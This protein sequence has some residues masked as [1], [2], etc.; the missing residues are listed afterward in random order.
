MPCMR[1]NLLQVCIR[2]VPCRQ[3]APQ[4]MRCTLCQLLRLL[5]C[6][7]DDMHGVTSCHIY[8]GRTA[9]NA[10]LVHAGVCRLPP[11]T[12]QCHRSHLCRLE[13]KQAS[14]GCRLERN[15]VAAVPCGSP[16]PTPYVLYQISKR[17]IPCFVKS[18]LKQRARS[19]LLRATSMLN[20]EDQ[21]K[22]FTDAPALCSPELLNLRSV[23]VAFDPQCSI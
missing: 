13:V 22:I 2:R 17:K 9:A 12:G 5:S 8:S 14:P 19:S 3:T 16:P 21:G 15:P 1:S 7:A 11:A 18:S 10:A 6:P 20:D 4:F 23:L